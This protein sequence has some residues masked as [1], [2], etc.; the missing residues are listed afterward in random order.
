[1][2]RLTLSPASISAAAENGATLTFK[3]SQQANVTVCVLNA[4]GK[5]MR[6][7]ARPGAAAGAV[8]IRYLV[9]KRVNHGLAS[10]R[11]T[12]LIVASNTHGSA[13]AAVALT[14]G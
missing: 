8:T 11:Y 3:L 6:T 14:V 1:V 9:H 13:T 4:N 5:V 7:V 2:T 10:G 12:V